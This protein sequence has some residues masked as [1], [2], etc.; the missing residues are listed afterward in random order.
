MVKAIR[1]WDMQDYETDYQYGNFMI[2]LSCP[3]P[4]DIDDAYRISY[5][6]KNKSTKDEARNKKASSAW[7]KW[8]KG[9]S[10]TGEKI[11]GG[12]TWWYRAAEY[13]AYLNTN[14]SMQEED[15][16]DQLVEKE[17]EDSAFMLDAWNSVFKNF[18]RSIENKADK[19]TSDTTLQ[20]R[21]L[22]ELTSIRQN[23]SDMARKAHRLPIRIDD[24]KDKSPV[25]ITYDEG[26]GNIYGDKKSSELDED[27]IGVGFDELK[28]AIDANEKINKSNDDS[29]TK[30]T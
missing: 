29:D 28:E 21:Q 6:Q 5:I 2:F 7:H 18:K 27:E 15:E 20:I 8:S 14:S 25:L 12:M 24:I 3:S 9:L 11:E 1:V 23:I 4:R 19:K 22:K 26:V 10:R 17:Q 30:T 13:D 16:R